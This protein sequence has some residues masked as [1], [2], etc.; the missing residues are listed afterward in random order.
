MQAGTFTFPTKSIILL[1]VLN[2]TSIFSAFASELSDNISFNNF[3]TLDISLADK[4]LAVIST[5]KEVRLFEGKELNLYNSVI[6]SQLS[7]QFSDD[8]SFV[9][10]GLAYFDSGDAV[11]LDLNWAYLHYD[12]GNDSAL[13]LGQFQTPLLQGTE[14]R[15]IGFSRLW[16]RP[17]IQGNGASGFNEYTGIEY[18]KRINQQQGSWQFQLG[19][20]Q[21]D[22]DLSFIDNKNIKLATAQYHAANYWLRTALIHIQYDIFTNDGG[23]ISDD[24]TA[25]LASVEAES[26]LRG[27]Q[28]NIGFSISNSDITPDDKMAYLS[29]AYPI[30]TLTPYIYSAWRNQEFE[31]FMVKNPQTVQ[32]TNTPNIQPPPPPRQPPPS[33]S[34]NQVNV[35]LGLRWSL[36]EQQ[37]LKVQFENIRINNDANARTLTDVELGNLFSI[38]IEGVF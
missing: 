30:G 12:L 31:S 6:G 19:L 25:L 7:Y 33:G 8:L 10:Q 14:L 11:T 27:I 2:T 20:G 17:L 16:A 26:T 4:D 18:S 36:S 9:V 22:H 28:F 3:Y 1:I 38:T 29:L 21:A 13:R 37:A 24:A 32:P 34:F 23:L 5:S 15:S 35:A